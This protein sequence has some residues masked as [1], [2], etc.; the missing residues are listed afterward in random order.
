MTGPATARRRLRTELLKIRLNLGLSD[1]SVGHD[2]GWLQT[3]L[4]GIET[5]Q[6]DIGLGVLRSLLAHYR[7]TDSHGASSVGYVTLT[8]HPEFPLPIASSDHGATPTKCSS[9]WC[10]AEVRPGAVRAAIGS[11]LLRS[12]GRM[13]PVQ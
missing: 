8:I 1:A 3:R 13:R 9:D 4:T 6:T 11:T 12:P 7:V 5:G 2:L 10:C